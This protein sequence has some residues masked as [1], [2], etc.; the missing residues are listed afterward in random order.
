VHKKKKRP[1]SPTF[2]TVCHRSW[3]LHFQTP[4]ILAHLSKQFILW[5]LIYLINFLFINFPC[6]IWGTSDLE[7]WFYKLWLFGPC[8]PWNDHFWTYI[9]VILMHLLWRCPSSLCLEISLDVHKQERKGEIFSGSFPPTAVYTP[10]ILALSEQKS[11]KDWK[12]ASEL[13]LP[14]SQVSCTFQFFQAAF[15]L[16]FPAAILPSR[17]FGVC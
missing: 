6:E 13:T 15:S 9:L 4:L 12:M 7:S 11:T 5:G 2:S 8:F 16:L 3:V 17:C 1:K 14:E 10:Q